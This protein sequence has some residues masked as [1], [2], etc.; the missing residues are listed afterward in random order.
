MANNLRHYVSRRGLRWYAANLV[1]YPCM[2]ALTSLF[3][4][5]L[6]GSISGG[7]G[8]AGQ[9]PAH[10]N[11]SIVIYIGLLAFS[12]GCIRVYLELEECAAIKFA[13]EMEELYRR[14]K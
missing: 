14:S 3:L 4:V 6:P 2:F 7:L 9:Q 13:T 11:Y 1:L 12:V 8:L 5:F 10:P